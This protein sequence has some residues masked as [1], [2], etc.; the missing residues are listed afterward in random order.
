MRARLVLPMLVLATLTACGGGTATPAD[1]AEAVDPMETA[2]AV[3]GS[4]GAPLDLGQG[5]T[6]TVS[7]P[8]AFKPGAYASNYLAGQVANL[9]TVSVQNTGTA[10]LDLSAIYFSVAS[11][12]TSCGDV[13]DG[14]NGINGAPTEPVAAG[15][16]SSFKYGIAC[17]A[18]AGDPL[19]VTA[20][21]GEASFDLKGTLA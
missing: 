3:A 2:A 15:G 1:T 12:E 16:E 21:F 14:D 18:K 17:D 20:T 9:V 6:L 5:I 11:G 7:Q 4:F 8:E 19:T 13:L 10:A